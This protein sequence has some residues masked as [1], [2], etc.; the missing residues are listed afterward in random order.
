MSSR[1]PNPGALKAMNAAIEKANERSRP[2][3]D[4][5]FGSLPEGAATVLGDIVANL[6]QYLLDEKGVTETE[7]RKLVAEILPHK[8]LPKGLRSVSH[9]A[10]D[11]GV[12][13]AI[14]VLNSIASVLRVR[15]GQYK[16]DGQALSKPDAIVLLLAGHDAL[17]RHRHMER[18]RTN[19]RKGSQV[20]SENREH[21]EA[22]WLPIAQTLRGQHPEWSNVKLATQVAHSK[23]V[24]V[25][26]STIRQALTRNGL[27]KT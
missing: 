5:V 10:A 15:D 17:Q 1:E 16:F 7:L 3:F 20:R 19:A 14:G 18:Q 13:V 25:S 9:R 26:V 27:S 22:Q 6:R 4:G 2:E 24:S 12:R 23:G 8:G 21:R 11:E